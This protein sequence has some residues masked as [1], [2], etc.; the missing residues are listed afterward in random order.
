MCYSTF[1]YDRVVN[2]QGE[3][4]YHIARGHHMYVGQ[5]DYAQSVL[6]GCEVPP[7]TWAYRVA[8]VSVNLLV[9]VSFA[10]T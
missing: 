4:A 3:H 1:G 10:A 2:Q 5:R 6:I 9:F 7:H 8:D